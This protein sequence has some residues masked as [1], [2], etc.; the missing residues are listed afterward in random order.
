M[1]QFKK[2][3]LR[4]LLAYQDQPCLSL[5]MP[6]QRAG[7]EVQQNHIRCKN[8]L[9]QA[10]ERL[11][12]RGLRA[13]EIQEL[14]QQAQEQLLNNSLFWQRQSNGLA[15]FIAP[16]LFHYYRL[17]LEFDEMVIVGRQFYIKPMLPLFKNAGHFYILALSQDE[18][19][20]LE[21]TKYR[22]DT[23]ELESL[24]PSL[25]EALKWDDPERQLQSHSVSRGREGG[26]RGPA[27][28]TFHGHGVGTDDDKTNI[29][30][31]FQKVDKAVSD[32]L[33]EERVPLILAGVE[34][35][36][37]IYREANSYNHL[38][39][40]G[41]PGNP[42]ELS[43]KALHA[44]AWDVVKP[45][46]QKEQEQAGAL[47]RQEMGR[48]SGRASSDVKEII[49]A[50]YSGRVEQLFVRD[51]AE[52]WGEYDLANNRV[53][54]HPERTPESEDLLN[55]AALYTFHNDGAIYAV[56]E[57]EMPDA[58]PIAVVFRY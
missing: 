7:A 3:H 26:E 8:L 39:E 45:F 12:A 14:L 23:L 44:R 20:L 25:A 49:P 27:Q 30:R 5:Y 16:D 57:S 47:H 37:P 10:E 54:V 38:V 32:F 1:D 51:N 4:D 53:E 33:A 24:P 48:Q 41:L 58:S 6:T 21:G 28:M 11:S 46:F 2:S 9:N 31:Y 50:A 55:T 40:R 22:V 15:V 18:V 34:Y 56:R 17:P 42:E 43:E 29:L 35:L 19:R 52:I 36:F 13:P